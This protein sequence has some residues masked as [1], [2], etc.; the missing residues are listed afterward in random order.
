MII[1]PAKKVAMRICSK[2][3]FCRISVLIVILLSANFSF[4]GSKVIPPASGVYHAAF[5]YFGP[6]EDRVSISTVT[7]FKVLVGKPIAWAYFSNNWF[8]GIKF[9][10][11]AVRAIHR[12]GA[13]PFV[14]LMP[15]S[16]FDLPD[17]VF[18][19]QKIIDGQFDPDFARWALDAKRVGI[20]IMVEFAGEPNGD[21]FP[22]SGS[23]NGGGE[24]TG[25][26]DASLA[27]G[28]ERYR[29]AYRHIIDV[30]RGQ[31]ADNI[32]WVFHLNSGSSPIASWNHMA[33]YYPGDD[34]ID[35]IGESAYG[36]QMHG[37]AWE[38]L[39]DVLD[40]SYQ[41]LSQISTAKPLA[42]FEYGVIDDG[43][44][45]HKASWIKEGLDSIRAGR[46]PR[47]KGV[48]YWHSKFRNDDGTI[49]N[50]RLD[51]SPD[52][53]QTYRSEVSD[54]FFISTV[55]Y[56]EVVPALAEA[57]NAP[58]TTFTLE[59]NYPNP[60]NPTT[61]IEY[62][63]PVDADVTLKVY[64]TLGQVVATLIDD[65]TESAGYQQIVFDATDLPSGVY[66]YSIV[67]QSENKLLTDVKRMLLVK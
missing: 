13:V 18:A 50:M 21:W 19:L 7:R 5:P 15:R 31:G 60:F 41:E 44:P 6:L 14:R 65:E 16:G 46:Y 43:I 29:D 54:P 67:A 35:W 33:A 34:Y 57:N 55:Q 58:P 42:I 27:D 9:S 20:P 45:G 4:A 56:S 17:T 59:Q 36:A 1:V 3:L 25:Y 39:T 40:R 30:F 61:A 24:T 2:Y 26:G 11:A 22:W 10:A 12:T 52:V 49:S 28:P 63:L 62:S 64:N 47:I 53:R 38:L 51:S 37:D 66:F 23:Q 48:S 8:R 32:T